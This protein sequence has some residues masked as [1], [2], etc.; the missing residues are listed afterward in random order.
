M[1]LK[2]SNYNRTMKNLKIK[3][4]ALAFLSL[5]LITSCANSD[6]YDNVDIV[7]QELTPTKTIDDIYA[8]ADATV[9][10]YTEDDVIEA[11]VASSDE[12]GTFYKSISF[13]NAD[14]TKGFSIPVDSYNLYTEVEPGRKVYIKLKDLY[15]TITHGSL[16]IGALYQ[17]TSVGRMQPSYFR[18]KV[19]ISQEK[20]AE[21]SVQEGGI[22]KVISLAD[23]KNDAYINTLVEI[24]NVQFILEDVG[25]TYYDANNVLG[26]ATNHMIEQTVNGTTSS[27]IFRTSEFAKFAGQIVPA[28]NGK[29]RGVLTKFNSDY[30]FMVRTINDVQLTNPRVHVSTAI[31][32]DDMTFAT[33]VN[34]GFESYATSTTS[35]AFDKYGNDNVA[36]GRY[37]SVRLFDNNK[38]I[39]LTAYGNQAAVTKSYFIV[40]VAFNGNNTL[41]FKTKDGHYNGDALNVYYVS[42][43]DYTYGDL[44]QASQYTNIT[45]QFTYSTGTTNGYA[46]TFVPSGNYQ[47]PSNVTGNGYIIF[48]YSG[49]TSVTTT[50]QIDDILFN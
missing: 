11:Y 18:E 4:L 6:D 22:V 39:Q 8:M 44:I 50:I 24:E 16:V 15:Y 46:N 34:E 43:N 32:G 30:Q 33:S 37:W 14:G 27:M 49:S 38:Y 31:G 25:S 23:L 45:S 28:N 41:S 26:G 35:T 40:P 36:G 10:Q 20:K 3:S 19:A 42:A 1:T 29:I 47:F 21:T 2:Y 9:K 13:Q 48:E 7:Y 17:E 5:G 12:G